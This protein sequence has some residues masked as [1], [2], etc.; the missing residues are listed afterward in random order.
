MQLEER[1]GRGAVTL[2]S[3]V[4]AKTLPWSAGES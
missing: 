3:S 1:R 2:N 4:M